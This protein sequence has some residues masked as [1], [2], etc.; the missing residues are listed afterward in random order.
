[1]KKERR[2][3]TERI[4]IRVFPEVK[5]MLERDAEKAGLSL[6]GLLK[7][8]ACG[9]VASLMPTKQKR[10]PADLELLRQI[11]G[12]LGKIGN[13]HNQIAHHLNQEKGFDMEKINFKVFGKR[14]GEIRI[15][16]LRALG[17][18]QQ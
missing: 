9:E 12:Q 8:R 10:L 2:Q 11:L 14:L 18:I 7:F 17:V 5:E 13:N 15:D 16:L 4:T 6:S 3:Q 1:M